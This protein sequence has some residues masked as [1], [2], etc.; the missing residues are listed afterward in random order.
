MNFTTFIVSTLYFCDVLPRR[1]LKYISGAHLVLYVIYLGTCLLTGW[2]CRMPVIWQ[3]CKHL[4][5]TQI[6]H[7]TASVLWASLA[8]GEWSVLLLPYSAVGQ[9][10][11]TCRL[12]S[13]SQS[14]ASNGDKI[15][16]CYRPYIFA[17]HKKMLGIFP[18]QSQMWHRVSCK[19]LFLYS[20]LVSL[21]WHPWQICYRIKSQKHKNGL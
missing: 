11:Q 17:L 9:C 16:S 5:M 20:F 14:E 13:W 21:Q 8:G 2:H 10:R 18:D 6:S 3:R 12:H 7:C 4:T 15:S 1:F 19:T